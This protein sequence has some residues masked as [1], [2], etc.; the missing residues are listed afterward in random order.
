MSYTHKHTHTQR[1]HACAAEG[2]RHAHPEQ[3]LH[4]EWVFINKVHAWW[5]LT[6][7]YTDEGLTHAY[8]ASCT[9]RGVTQ[10]RVSHTQRYLIHVRFTRAAVTHAEQAVHSAECCRD[11]RM[12]G[13]SHTLVCF[14]SAWVCHTMS[15]RQNAFCTLG[16][17]S[18]IGTRC[19]RHRDVPDTG[20]SKRT[21]GVSDTLG[22]AHGCY[23][24]T[25][26]VTHRL[27]QTLPTHTGVRHTVSHT[28]QTHEVPHV[29][30]FTDTHGCLGIAD[31]VTLIHTG[32]SRTHVW[33]S[34][35]H[36]RGHTV[37]VPHARCHTHTG[38]LST[39]VP[40][41]TSL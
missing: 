11:T 12:W 6:R 31:M 28:H 14:I 3:V 38:V 41:T 32:V 36:T 1:S 10:I 30:P 29:A 5:C 33:V 40:H 20:V 21:R 18:Q 24:H 8:G 15:F 2:F 13:V 16:C 9:H 39:Q 19:L 22:H 17:V 37:S 34:L 23:G 4:T 27:A 26:C 7:M 25:W 35:M